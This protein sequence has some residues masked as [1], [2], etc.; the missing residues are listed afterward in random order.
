[1]VS[2]KKGGIRLDFEKHLLLVEGEATRTLS[3]VQEETKKEL[4]EKE[5]SIIQALA[6]ENKIFDLRSKLN[7][8]MFQ[9][10]RRQIKAPSVDFNR[11]YLKFGQNSKLM[12]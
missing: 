3:E 12:K 6:T 2:E 1:M 8:K 9:S 10:E 7:G 5:Q 4:V 11:G